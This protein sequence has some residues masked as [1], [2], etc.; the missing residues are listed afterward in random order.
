MHIATPRLQA[1]TRNG[2]DLLNTMVNQ[3]VTQT[4]LE[5]PLRTL[6]STNMTTCSCEHAHNAGK[7]TKPQHTCAKKIAR[8]R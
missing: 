1:N 8:A 7:Q 3:R 5:L 2:H 6:R 4:T